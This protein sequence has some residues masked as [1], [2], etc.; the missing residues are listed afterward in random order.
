MKILFQFILGLMLI[1]IVTPAFAELG[2]TV[3]GKKGAQAASGKV[4]KTAYYALVIGNNDYQ[5]LSRLST[6]VHDAKEVNRVLS[7][8]YGFKT[9]LLVN[10]T[11]KDILSTIN[12][13]RKKLNEGD[14]FLIYYAGH[15]AYD[16]TADKGYWLPVDAAKGGE[17]DF[18]VGL[19]LGPGAGNPS[20]CVVECD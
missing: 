7:E 1:L 17:L 19:P 5:N 2:V 18:W 15:G 6:A 3:K 13:F 14:S 12:D 4:L 8:K 16:K 11:R 10:A 9:I 20:S